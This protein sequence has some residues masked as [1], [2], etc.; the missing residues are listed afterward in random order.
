MGAFDKLRSF[1]EARE[2]D[3]TVIM[4]GL[5]YRDARE[6]MTDIGMLQSR[7]RAAEQERDAAVE[8]KL[9]AEALVLN[10]EGHIA[11]L[12]QERD[13]AQKQRKITHEEHLALIADA[14]QWCRERDEARADLAAAGPWLRQVLHGADGSAY[15]EE[16]FRYQVKALRD[17]IKR[18]EAAKEQG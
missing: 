7:L 18:A 8:A 1:A 6:A 13:E 17:L 5:T 12:E 16:S 3:E 10:H 14:A 4:A 2:G 15:S 9:V 11:K